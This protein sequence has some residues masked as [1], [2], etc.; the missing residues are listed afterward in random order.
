VVSKWI[1]AKRARL[2]EDE[3]EIISEKIYRLLVRADLDP[4]AEAIARKALE[5]IGQ[6]NSI[7]ESQHDALNRMFDEHRSCLESDV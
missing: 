3:L 7:S 4:K 1:P 5:S 2:S 6:C